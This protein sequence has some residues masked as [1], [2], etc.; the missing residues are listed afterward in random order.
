MTWAAVSAGHDL[1]NGAA[2]LLLGGTA[3]LTAVS[4]GALIELARRAASLEELR[5]GGPLDGTVT[6]L[7]GPGTAVRLLLG[8]ASNTASRLPAAMAEGEA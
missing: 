4:I 7:E 8:L 2:F 1:L 3:L 5:A 6:I